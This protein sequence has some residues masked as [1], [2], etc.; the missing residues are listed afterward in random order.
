MP[1]R[2]SCPGCKTTLAVKDHL[3]GKRVKC[4][5]CQAPLSV[6]AAVAKPAVEVVKQVD[7][8]ALAAA[9]F[10]GDEPAPSP[11]PAKG[12]N[13]SVVK[14]PIKF[15]CEYCEAEVVVDA[16]LAGK[17]A[18]CPECRH[19]LKVP[20][21]KEEKP[22]DWRTVE[23]K[24][25]SAALAN[26]PEKI[27]NAW[28]TETKAKVSQA[29]LLEAGVI[30]KPKAPPIG[31]A[32][33]LG[34]GFK[35][36]TIVVVVG[37]LS[38]GLWSLRSQNAVLVK[39]KEMG[40]ADP[41]WP[42]VIQGEFHILK[43]DLALQQPK[44]REAA[45][46]NYIKAFQRVAV[47]DD[48]RDKIDRDFFL[49]RLARAQV[50]L[51]GDDLAIRGQDRFEWNQEVFTEINRTVQKIDNP[52]AQIS[53]VRELSVAFAEIKKPELA[54]NL[55]NSVSALTPQA[56]SI[57]LAILH[58]ENKAVDAKR[59]APFP[60]GKSP[61]DLVARCGYAEGLVR[62]DKAK[63]K[64]AADIAMLPG[65]NGHRFHALIAIAAALAA[66]P[67]N[68]AADEIKQACDKASDILSKDPKANIAGWVLLQHVRLTARGDVAAAKGLTQKLPAPFRR[69]GKVEIALVQL[70]KDPPPA[71][72]S[73]IIQDLDKD[74]PGRA[75]AWLALARCK[76][77]SFTF[78][79]EEPEDE[80][81]RPFFKAVEECPLIPEKDLRRQ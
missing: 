61:V 45:R 8:E 41:K 19:I 68:A 12:P 38:W 18:P 81:L 59:I 42:A 75:L 39:M 36:A 71:T 34:R 72:I 80:V 62:L 65:D 25:P 64:E 74:G 6:P 47:A 1:I 14:A 20:L 73:T 56:K 15:T 24:G 33:W 26:Q 27:D 21:P 3:A 13:G 63:F 53:A 70:E 16:E 66:D 50:K 67:R 76:R 57:R 54:I 17:K 28:G 10:G 32:G 5:K 23:K 58:A 9:A 22:K 43:A 7:V 46:E 60:D 2:V 29:A 31:V 77:A 79:P 55:A 49:I 30:E 78:T 52:D 44:Q 69:R 40:N 37:G 51:G 35:A 4:P 11:P 48:V